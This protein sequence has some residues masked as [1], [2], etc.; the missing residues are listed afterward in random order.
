MK[1]LLDRLRAGHDLTRDEA[2]AA[3]ESIVVGE[4]EDMREGVALAQQTVYSG[5]ARDKLKGL[6]RTTTAK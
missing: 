4:T 1:P 5:A 2:R 6:I 3:F